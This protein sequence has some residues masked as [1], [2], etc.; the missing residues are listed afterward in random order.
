MYEPKLLVDATSQKLLMENPKKEHLQVGAIRLSS[1]HILGVGFA[2]GEP[3]RLPESLLAKTVFARTQA[4]TAIG[5]EYTLRKLLAVDPQSTPAEMAV[6][7]EAIKDTIK[8]KGRGKSW[9]LPL[10]ME[11]A[12]EQM[13]GNGNAKNPK[14]AGNDA[15]KPNA[16]EDA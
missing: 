12:L 11:T 16:G 2:K 15:E 13:S 10:F 4:K 8:R 7:A 5:V 9:N 3:W 6:A 1:L 14:V